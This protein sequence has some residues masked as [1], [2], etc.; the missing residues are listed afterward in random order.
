MSASQAPRLGWIGLGSM[1][2]AMALNVQKYLVAN[3]HPSLRYTNRTMSR[4]APLQDIGA[5]PCERAEDIA[6]SCSIIFISM[7]NDDALQQIITSLLSNRVSLMNKVIVDTT[8]IHPDTS[9]RVSKR[10]HLAGASFISAPV[11][12][13]TPVAQAGRL[14]I[15]VAGPA[16]AIEK[17]QPFLKGVI[18]RDVIYVSPD[19]SKALLLKTTSN[20]L[21]AGLHLLMSEAHVFA[22]KSGLP[23][24]VLEELVE[25]NFG[26]YAHGVSKR[27]TDGHYCPPVGE[28]PISGLDL[29]MKDVGIGVEFARK[30]GMRLEVGEMVLARMKE[31]KAWAG[32]EGQ[33]RQLDSTSLFGVVREKAGLEFRSEKVKQRDRET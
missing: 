20:F 2:Q 24:S 32:E 33:G 17:V 15:A 1:G 13:A 29:G 7:S 25:Q 19:S 26:A 22:E 31:A 28:R 14:L 9:S 10:L 6:Q 27:L 30:K 4:G 5:I 21:T 18:A 16:Q 3:N 8:T 11:F 23:S 12:G